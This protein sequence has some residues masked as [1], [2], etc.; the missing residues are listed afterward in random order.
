MINL[1]PG[2]LSSEAKCGGSAP[3]VKKEPFDIFIQKKS[4]AKVK[5][6]VLIICVIKKV[7]D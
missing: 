2:A 5:K 6:V 4:T 3:K 7:N 1:P